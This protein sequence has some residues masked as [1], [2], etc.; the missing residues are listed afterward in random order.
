MLAVNL[1]TRGTLEALDLLEYSN[2]AG[3][4]ALSQRRIENGRTDAVRREDVVPRQRDGRP[5]AARPPLGRRLRQA[6]L[7]HREG[8]APARPVDRARGVRLVERAH[9]DLRRVGARRARAHLRRRRLHLVPRLLR[10]EGRRPRQLP[11]LGGRHGPLHR[12][13]RR[14]RRPREGR[15][16]QRQ[17][18]SNISFDEWNVWYLVAVPGR[19]QDR[20][21]RQLAR[22]AAPARGRL[23]RG[24]RRR[25]RQPDD[26]AAQ[27][28][29]PRHE[30]LARAA[31]ERHRADHDRA[32]RA[33]VAADHVLPVRDHLA[34][35]AGRGARAEARRA[36][37]T[38][39]HGTARS[40]SSTP[41]PPT[42]PRPGARRSSS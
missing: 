31:R 30:R 15:A 5:V 40:R 26:L 16:R 19:R 21:H 14:D 3:G 34:A 11:R 27:A 18:R 1:G 23:L 17:D 20:G 37:R 41:W 28:R 42:T 12:D 7:A 38:R 25:V 9:A 35:R 6:R 33:G 29:R 32:R 22:R 36:R 39:P 2:I 13:R 4:T 10:G 24:R 8:D